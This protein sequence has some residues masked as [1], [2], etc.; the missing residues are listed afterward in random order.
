MGLE[1]ITRYSISTM[2]STFILYE[3][4]KNEIVYNGS[5]KSNIEIGTYVRKRTLDRNLK[6]LQNALDYEQMKMEEE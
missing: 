2:K 6:T 5:L 4:N 1:A 3:D